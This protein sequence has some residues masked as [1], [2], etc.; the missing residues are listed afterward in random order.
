MNMEKTERRV[1]RGKTL[2]R[3]FDEALTLVEEALS[4]EGFGVLCRIP[5]SQTLETKLGVK[6]PRTE[7]LGA[8]NPS[9]AHE[10]LSA[11]PEVS[12]MLP[13]NVV[14]R[15]VGDGQTRV[16]VI[17]ARTMADFF[18]ALESVA[19]RVADRLERVL[20]RI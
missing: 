6:H 15:D 10:A 12:L 11:D 2:D 4:A 18:P 1:G 14:V 17:D 19:R 13:C 8:C 5:V 9:C 20:E 7:I 3:G 16:D